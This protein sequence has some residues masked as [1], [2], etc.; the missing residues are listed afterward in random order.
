MRRLLGEGA[1]SAAFIPAFTRAL[2]K[3]GVPSARA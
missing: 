3:D 1:L 2:D